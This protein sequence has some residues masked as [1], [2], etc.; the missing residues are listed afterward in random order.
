MKK[1]ESK[2]PQ[3][4]RIK[5][6]TKREEAGRRELARWLDEKFGPITDKEMNAIRAEWRGEKPPKR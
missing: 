2:E 5:K 1:R 6:L 4:A 3:R